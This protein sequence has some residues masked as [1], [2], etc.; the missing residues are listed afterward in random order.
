VAVRFFGGVPSN[1]IHSRW[2]VSVGGGGGGSE[3]DAAGLPYRIYRRR[4]RGG[5]G[6]QGGERTNSS[7]Y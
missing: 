6:G 7:L 4:V 2:G 3:M 5:G 1:L